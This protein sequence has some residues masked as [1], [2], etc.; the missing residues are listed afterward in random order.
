[1]DPL[2]GQAHGADIAKL[3]PATCLDVRV[4][5]A[6]RDAR[7]LAA[8]VPQSVGQC[9]PKTGPTCAEI[10]L[11]ANGAD[12]VCVEIRSTNGSGSVWLNG[13]DLTGLSAG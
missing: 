5:G 4:N 10:T 12:A 6:E 9:V 3:P 11:Q 2:H 13:L 7:V 1:M 8:F